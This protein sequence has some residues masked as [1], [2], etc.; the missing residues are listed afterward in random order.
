MMK[1][2]LALLFRRAGAREAARIHTPLVMILS[3]LPMVGAIAYL[4]SSPLRSKLLVRV[5]MDEVAIELPFGLYYRLHLG[6]WLAP[7]AL[8]AL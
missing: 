2:Q 5:A 7:S 1:A 8:S 6:R 4:S 3:L